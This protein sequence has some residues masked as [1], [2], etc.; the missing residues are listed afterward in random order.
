MCST[1]SI[2]HS[3]RT[4]LN[5]DGLCLVSFSLKSF[6]KIFDVFLSYISKLNITSDGIFLTETMFTDDILIIFQPMY[7]STLLAQKN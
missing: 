2:D 1:F 3:N 5:Y 4:S 7:L 6:S